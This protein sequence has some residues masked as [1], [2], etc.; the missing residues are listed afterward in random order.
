LAPGISGQYATNHF[1]SRSTTA[2]NSLCI[3]SPRFRSQCTMRHTVSQPH[4]GA[5]RL[6]PHTAV[7]PLCELTCWGLSISCVERHTHPRGPESSSGRQ[8]CANVPA[9]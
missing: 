4:F 3:F 6:R 2:V 9:P 7:T 5:E 1:P 8:S